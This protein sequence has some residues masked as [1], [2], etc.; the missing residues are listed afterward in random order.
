MQSKEAHSPPFKKLPQ[1]NTTSNKRLIS[2]A[3][4]STSQ[5]FI[6]LYLFLFCKEIVEIHWFL[7]S[8]HNFFELF[9][10]VSLCELE[11]K[12]RLKSPMPE[13]KVV[14]FTDLLTYPADVLEGLILSVFNILKTPSIPLKIGIPHC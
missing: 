12:E 10:K 1:T 4:L 14:L 7:V 13:V 11:L 2:N 3:I 9:N 6:Y 5:S 8:V